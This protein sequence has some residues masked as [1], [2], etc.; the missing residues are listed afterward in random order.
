M[1]K[2]LFIIII[3]YGLFLLSFYLLQNQLLFIGAS[4]SETRRK[5]IQAEFP[6]A[7]E[8]FIE[9]DDNIKLHGWFVHS[10]NKQ[11]EP[12]PLVMYFGGNAEEVSWVIERQQK[13][14][15][16]YSFLVVNYRG[17]GIS[18]GRPSEENLFN[19]AIFLYDHFSSRK[20]VDPEQIIVMGWSL[21]TGVA[22]HL[23]YKR[24][25]KKVI[26]ISPYDSML[27]VTQNAYPFLPVKWLM[28]NRF[29]VK[30]KAK[31]IDTPLIAII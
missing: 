6:K 5:V 3:I 10:Q 27:N 26:L 21:G 18:E 8:V 22:T 4:L 16:D 20:E 14:L 31:K 9:T 12:K 29:M 17:Y 15:S 24:E 11:T 23:A 25:I 7:E 2:I 19:D 30:D 28:K 13:Y 1:K